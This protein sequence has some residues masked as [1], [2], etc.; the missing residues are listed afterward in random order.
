[1]VSNNSRT[2][3]GHQPLAA[4]RGKS[5][6]I[7]NGN[8]KKEPKQGDSCYKKEQDVDCMNDCN[9]CICNCVGRRLRSISCTK[10]DC[11]K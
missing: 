11:C 7:A 5:L 10:I 1:M 3:T 4:A 6:R 8:E 9:R 2:E